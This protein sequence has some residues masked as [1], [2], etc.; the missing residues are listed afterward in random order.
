MFPQIPPSP[1]QLGWITRFRNSNNGYW[2]NSDLNLPK[3]AFSS[4]SRDGMN[5]EVEDLL[6]QVSP[7]RMIYAVAPAQ[8]NNDLQWSEW[9]VFDGVGFLWCDSQLVF[10]FYNFVGLLGFYFGSNRQRAGLGLHGLIVKQ[11]CYN[12][13]HKLSLKA[14]NYNNPLYLKVVLYIY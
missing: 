13:P 14:Q 5:G 2:S 7:V 11:G 3:Q 6:S 1:Q 10:H 4:A 8:H 12:K 9:C